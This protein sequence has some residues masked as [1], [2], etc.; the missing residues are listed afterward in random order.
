MVSRVFPAGLFTFINGR[1]M[2]IYLWGDSLILG[3]ASDDN[4]R[5]EQL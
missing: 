3:R 5:G 2:L 1:W 4:Q